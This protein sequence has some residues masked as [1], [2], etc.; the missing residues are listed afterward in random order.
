MK[1]VRHYH[2]I[3]LLPVPERA[4]NGYKQYRVTHLIRL[5]RIR[6][7]VSLGVA[8]ADI[9]QMDDSAENAEPMFRALDAELATSIERQQRMR[10]EIA[11]ILRDG[12][13]ADLPPGFVQVADDLSEADRAFALLGARIFEPWVMETMREL[14]AAPRTEAGREFETLPADASEE[15]RQD[16]AVRFAPE[17]RRSQQAHPRLKEWVDDRAGGDPRAWSALLQGVV[18]LYNPAQIDVLQRIDG[19]IDH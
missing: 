13:L 8:L 16:L 9:E 19:L 6:R 1:A 10:E 17:L 7:L 14:F 11:M 15:V 5:L 18:E 4:A 2:R 3:G 12:E